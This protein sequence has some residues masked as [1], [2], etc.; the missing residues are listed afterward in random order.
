M[1]FAILGYQLDNAEVLSALRTARRHLNS[2]G[3]FICLV[4][5]HRGAHLVPTQG[6]G[7]VDSLDSL[8]SGG[9]IKNLETD[10]P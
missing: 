10:Q 2:G 6:R 3:R 4:S 7:F 5:F 8:E 1:M 9:T